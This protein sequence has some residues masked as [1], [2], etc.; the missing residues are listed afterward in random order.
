MIRAPSEYAA[1]WLSRY[2]RF[3]VVGST[4]D[5]V[6]G[7]LREG[8]PEVC[9]A[10]ADVQSAGRGRDGRTWQSPPGAALLCS[11]GFRPTWLEIGHVWRLGAIVSLAMA[12]ACEVAGGLRN[13]AIHLKWPNDLV[14]ID[15]ATGEVRKLAGVLGETEGIGT[16]DATAVIGIGANVSWARDRFPGE[17]AGTMTSLS[18]LAPGK[19]VDREVAIHVFLQRLERLVAALRRGEFPGETWSRRQLTN[20]MIVM[21]D[22]PDGTAQRVVAE[23]VDT[24][25]GALLVR[26]PSDGR[27]RPV[28][29][30]EIRHLRVG[31]IV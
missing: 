6:A 18:E 2:E 17:L 22:Q 1:S 23:N 8:T 28:V 12:E 10:I 3:D 29:V 14:I 26:E 21:L 15:H 27:T 25:T 9:V 31:G 20:G 16:P 11:V 24:E 30:G 7:W 13:G 4:N 19:L 5:V